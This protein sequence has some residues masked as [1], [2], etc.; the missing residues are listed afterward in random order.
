MSETQTSQPSHS[1]GQPE[2]QPQESP[3]RSV[4]TSNFP[5]ILSRLGITLVVS[6]YQ[7]GKL[8]LV[9][10]DEG[11]LNTHF[12][13]F[14]KPMGLAG[15]GRR[16]TVGTAAEVWELRNMPDVARKLEP[17]GKH[18]ALYMPRHM[19][20]TGDID[21]HEMA[22]GEEG[23]W[24]VNTRFSC[25]CTI[26]G[27]HSFV[28][29]WR[30]PF[31]SAFAPQDRCHL[32][33][34]GMVNGKPRYATA[35][36]ETDS[37]EKWRENK[38][39]GGILMDIEHD[40]VL[41][42]ELSMPHS[43]RWYDGRLWMLESGNGSLTVVDP[44]AGK[45]QTVVKLPGFTR[46]LDFYGPLAF[47]GLSKVRDSALFSGIPLTERLE[48]RI[49]GVWVVNIQSGEIVAF[50]RFEEAVQEIFAVKVL[51]GV[52]FPDIS[53]WTDKRIA[54]SYVLPDE[55]LAHVPPQLK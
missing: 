3:L 54:T 39:R 8:I 7:A 55:A 21:I 29:K 4:H 1:E 34:L 5:E 41:L 43:P 44:E 10:A 31:I 52:R 36:G 20:V 25:L 37:N 33:G 18:D 22:W 19:H 27:D 13:N 51:H 9:R 23:L 26:D 46:G 15:D 38:A 47:I 2:P 32:N 28:P 45:L 17:A 40:E 24:I 48:D 49:C 6:T 16:L 30:P 42:R 35:L 50:I 12:R 11:R 14:K 53:D